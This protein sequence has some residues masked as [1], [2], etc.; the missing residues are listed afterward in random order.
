MQIANYSDIY[1]EDTT[2]RPYQQNA[3]QEIFA[4][5]DEVDNV[6]FQMPTGTGKTRLFSSIISDINKYSIQQREAV[7]I[8]IIAHRTEL[9]EQIDKHLDKYRVPHN[10]IAGGRE[11]QY[12]Y[13]VSIASIQTI[14]NK[15]NLVEAKRLNVQF[16][17][18]D[19]AHH[20]LAASYQKLWELYPDAKRLGVTATPWR[21]NHQSFLDLFDKLILSLPIKEFIRR[22]Y[23]SPYKYFSL[24]S[25][26]Y[27]QKTIDD[28]EIDRFGEYKESSMEEKMDIGSI[29]AQLLESY[30][31][32]ARGK[33]GIIYAINIV[34]AKHICQEYE[35]AG[36]KAV[37]IDSKTPAKIRKDLV[38]QFK[39]GKVDIIVNVD[40]FSEGFDCPDIEFIQ[41]AR[42]TRSLVKYLQQV[43]R[44]LRVT[45]NKDNCIILDN[46]GMYSRFGLPDARRHWR[47]HFLGKKVV[48]ESKKMSQR[49]GGGY[50]YYDLSE[51]TED[52]ELIQDVSDVVE[53]NEEGGD[54]D[55]EMV[56]SPSA[57]SSIFHDLFPLLGFT[58]GKT[59]W[60]EAGEMG[61]MVERWRGGKARTTIKEDI[62]FWD[63]EGKGVFT[64]LYWVY[65]HT[66]F[67]PSWKEKGF[68][69]DNSYVEWMIMFKQ[70]GFEQ[71]VTKK[72]KIV[73]YRGRDTL[74]AQLEAL[75]PDR[76]LKFTLDFNY[77]ENGHD[78][79]SP[80]TLYSLSAN[81]YG[82]YEEIAKEEEIEEDEEELYYD[83]NDVSYKLGCEI[84]VSYPNV[85]D[86][87]MIVLPRFIT[88]INSRAFKDNSAS[89]IILHDEI[90]VLQGHLFE[91]CQN[92]KTIT[93]KTSTPDDIMIDANSFK[94]FD[95]EDCVL[96]VPFDALM[97]YKSDD[98][99][100][101]FKYITAIE[102]SRCL[103]Y[104]D[105]ELMV[106]GCDEEDC[107]TLQIPEGV[108]SIKE[109]AL[110]DNTKIKEV[111]FP[112]SLKVIGDCAFSGCSGIKEIKL[113]RSLEEIGYDAFRGTGLTEVEIPE[114]VETIGFSAF[115]CNMKV[116]A[117]NEIYA[118]KGGILFDHDKKVLKI[119]PS[120]KPSTCYEIRNG[121]EVISFY[122]FEDSVLKSISL[123]KTIKEL[124]SH[125]F[126][127]CTE[128]KELTIKVENPNTLKIDKD[129]FKGFNAKRCTLIVPSGCKNKYASHPK[130]KGFM[131]IVEK[132]EK[133]AKEVPEKKHE[134][135]KAK[136]TA[137]RVLGQSFVITPEPMRAVSKS[138]FFR[139]GDY[140]CFI[141]MTTKALYLKVKGGAFYFLSEID[142]KFTFG[143]IWIHNRN[144]N[145]ASYKVSFS[146]DN[147]TSTPFGMIT[148]TPS[149]LT[150]RDLK[151]GKSF[152]IN[153][154]RKII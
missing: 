14:T 22:G 130:F 12:K 53:A 87:E 64:S 71:K 150:Y 11:K 112:T 148:E 126:S 98:R 136:K 91:G 79:F 151:T 107:S 1:R 138:F 144:G 31:K 48:E 46:V 42:P 108:T 116:S 52:M 141:E 28:I 13:P 93:L 6:M 44:G 128:L 43:G 122:A 143:Q 81:F 90:V 129:V 131:K 45:E 147:K 119:Y 92:L 15:N 74:S 105:R 137:K 49:K 142:T 145:L 38:E 4:A 103:M 39:M 20:A 139:S 62:A 97:L 117:L 26:S 67:P 73:K 135:E 41:L 133:G 33:K 115:N 83:N 18:I 77:G 89:E 68:A 118:D 66:D 63:H 10:V 99:F 3:K 23:L 94:G 153:F 2:L 104:D 34:H 70:L 100:K 88:Q 86:Y 57:D 58:L 25:D 30:Q 102:G 5:W 9:I 29:R 8:L 60:E 59:T 76:H 121:V 55:S 96:R 152:T 69:W 78:I 132:G 56:V 110:E 16:V 65:F 140:R 146:I 109:D 27:I 47:Y 37:S 32:L 82:K 113:N 17:I 36:Y 101:G 154:R 95:V 120:Q 24:K 7:K 54:S 123:A 84:L 72:P 114:N 106:V 21:M 127:G 124:K 111:T 134:V 40:I 50:R 19:E 125:I 61:C 149:T 35:H 80:D 75:S 85:G 51:G